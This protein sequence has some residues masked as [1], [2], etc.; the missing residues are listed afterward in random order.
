MRPEFHDRLETQ[1]GGQTVISP[2]ALHAG[3]GPTVTESSAPLQ[4]V[5][6][7][8]GASG[9]RGA[10]KTF[11]ILMGCTPWA[12][13]PTEPLAAFQQQS[14][15][16]EPRPAQG[17][18][19]IVLI[20][21][22]DQ[23]YGDFG[24]MGSPD[25]HT[26]NIDRLAAASARYV[27][28]YVPSSVCRP[29]LATI[30]TG[31][32]PHQHGIYFNHGPPGNA[33][34]NRMTSAEEY[35]RVRSR[36]FGLI[37]RVDTLPRLLSEQ[38]GYCTLQTG[39]FWEGHYRNAGFSH[40]LTIFKAV[41]GQPYGGNRILAGGQRVAHGNGDAGL[42]IGRE[43]MQPIYDFID[44]CGENPFLIWYAP[45]LPH[46]PHDAP[47]RF[48]ERYRDR[49]QVAR[50]RIPY[51]ASISQFDETV[52]ALIDFVEK[53]GLALNTIFVFVSDNGWE[54][55]PREFQK[56][57]GQ[58]EHT[59][60]SKRAPFDPGLRTP[61]LIRFD[62]HIKPATHAGL[63]S[64]IDVMPTLLHA[65]G[66]DKQAAALPGV[67]LL[68]SATGRTLLDADRT[69]FGAIYPGDAQTL[70]DASSNVAYRWARCGPL[71]LIVTHPQQAPR[72]WGAYLSKD[73]LF[74]VVRDP[75]ETNNLIGQA[76]Y[77][78]QLAELRDLLDAWWKPSGKNQ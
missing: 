30:L 45:F 50:H 3:E 44:D 72:P 39:K 41:P 40:G 54:P 6:Q 2:D 46:Q 29:S 19:N 5:A 59:R 32:Y 78:D 49:P 1:Q 55:S 7:S 4:P 60:R 38:L 27:N 76:D 65:V 66:L 51:L 21:S 47:P 28:G 53:R 75:G 70:D 14:A 37:R 16:Q 52:G 71:K 31:L 77:D 10:W 63:A 8:S 13:V 22:D 25:A 62:G 56:T 64:S 35:V 73:A 34:Y 23:A 57:P 48:Y 74:D 69:L 33:A 36:E 26:P 68:P 42:R 61:I 67:N 9:R 58:F 24:F 18:P 17:R 20:I 15:A 12:F 43:T 11:A